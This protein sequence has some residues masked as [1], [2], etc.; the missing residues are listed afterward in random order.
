MRFDVWEPDAIDTRPFL[1]HCFKKL[2]DARKK[3]DILSL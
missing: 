3:S 1:G 2:F